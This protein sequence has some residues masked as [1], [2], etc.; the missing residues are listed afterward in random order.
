MLSDLGT[1]VGNVARAEAKRN[2][3]AYLA[4]PSH[5]L[6]FVGRQLCQLS[7]RLLDSTAEYVLLLTVYTRF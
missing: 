5:P 2:D 4:L 1:S 6:H 7:L 3:F